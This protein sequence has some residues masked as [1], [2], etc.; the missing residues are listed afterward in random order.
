MSLASKKPPTAADHAAQLARLVKHLG[1]ERN[2]AEFLAAV[3]TPSELETIL[4]RITIAQLLD[5]NLSY[6]EIQSRLS[7]SSATVASVAS[8]RSARGYAIAL[9]TIELISATDTLVAKLLPP[10][11]P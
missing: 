9:D 7:V 10:A 6:Q 1:N 8:R 11:K 2:V 4:K 5:Q 3:C